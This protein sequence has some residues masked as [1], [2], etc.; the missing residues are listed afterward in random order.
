MFL[1]WISTSVS[2]YFDVFSHFDVLYFMLHLFIWRIYNQIKKIARQRELAGILVSDR[3]KH[4][5]KDA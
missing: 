5:P 2:L 1:Y 3:E 4:H